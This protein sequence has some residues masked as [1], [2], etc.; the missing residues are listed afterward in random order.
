MV[1]QVLGGVLVSADLGGTQWRPIFLV[2]VPI[3][4]AGLWLARTRLPETRS[5]R[6]TRPDVAGTVLLAAAVVTRAAPADR[7]P[8]RGLAAVVAW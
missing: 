4:L 5:P 6:P 2:N 3:G 1:G 7:G 8:R